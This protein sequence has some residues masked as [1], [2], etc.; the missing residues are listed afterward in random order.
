MEKWLFSPDGRLTIRAQRDRDQSLFEAG[1]GKGKAQFLTSKNLVEWVRAEYVPPRRRQ[2]AVQDDRHF[3]GLGISHPCLLGL[4]SL[5]SRGNVGIQQ[6]LRCC[7]PDA[8]RPSRRS[9][10]RFPSLTP[11]MQTLSRSSSSRFP[12]LT[13]QGQRSSQVRFRCVC[14]YYCSTY[15]KAVRVCCFCL[16]LQ[17][18]IQSSG[19]A[20]GV[21]PVRNSGGAPFSLVPLVCMFGHWESKK[22]QRYED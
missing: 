20:W 18:L 16:L 17:Y 2:A 14:V 19:C 13:S 9:S 21:G 8:R 11:T 15:Y 3:R 6:A 10:S 22:R 12:S 5:V 4:T 7:Q 1:G